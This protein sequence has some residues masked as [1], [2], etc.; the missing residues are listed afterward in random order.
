[1][2][3]PNLISP[4]LDGFYIGTA[5]SQHDGVCC[6]PAKKENSDQRYIVKVL[7][8]PPS[9]SQLEALLLTGAFR[10]TGAAVEY[11]RELADK[12]DR[13]A[14]CL[15][16]LARLEGFLAFDG[17]Q[18]VP[19]EQGS[20]GFEVWLLC[21]YRNSLEQH[22]RRNTLSHLEALNLGIDMCNALSAARRA[23][24]I[25]VDLKPSNIFISES[26]EYRIGDLGLMELDGLDLAALP[27]KYRSAYTAPELQDEMLSPNTTLDTYAL[28]LILYRIYN[29][30]Q[31]PQVVHPTEDVLPP[32]ANADYELSEILLKACDPNPAKRWESPVEM[33]QALVAYMQ[34]N[35]V[36][37]L[38]IIPP[39]AELDPEQEPEDLSAANQDETLP[40]MNEE[41]DVSEEELSPEMAKMMEQADELIQHEL[42]AP[43]VVPEGTTLEAL[44]AELLKSAESG[45][46]ENPELKAMLDHLDKQEAAQAVPD[47]SLDIQ[48]A[49]IL[50]HTKEA[51]DPADKKTPSAKKEKAVKQKKEKSYT[52][53]DHKR[54]KARFKS[55][56]ITL[57]V[58]LVLALLGYAGFRYYTDCYVQMIH[59]LSVDGSEDTMTVLLDAD[60]D[61]ELLTVICTDTFGNTSRQP[62]E[63]GRAEF[64]NLLPD[65]LYQIR[66]EIEGFHRLAG[67]TT[68]EY[69]T[70]AETRIVSYTAVTGPEDGSVILNF[71][72]DGPDSE[73]WTAVCTAEGAETVSSRFTGHMA[74]VNGLQVGT[75]YQIRLVPATGLYIP[76]E[77]SL[78]FT[79]AS[80]IIA[81]NLSITTDGQGN[82][83]VTWQAPEGA[84][85]DS[86]DVHCYSVDGYEQKLTTGE[87]TATFQGISSG[88]A[89][90]VEVTAAGM[91][92][93][94]RAGITANPIY[95]ENIQV[96]DNNLKNLTV[97]WDFTGNAPEGGWLL[98]YTIDGS[99]H[100]QVV[101]CQ[102][103]SGVI[104]V[105]VPAATYDLTIQAADGSTVF[106]NTHSYRT[107]NT[108]VYQNAP[109]AFY[110]RAQAGHFFVNMLKTPEIAN[111]NHTHVNQ[112]MYTTTFAPGDGVSVLMYYMK[113]FYIRHEDIT[114][115]YV[116]RDENGNVLSEYIAIEN[117]DWRDDLWNGPNYHY[118]AL[119]VPLVPTEPGKYI[120]GIYFDGQAMTAAE[121]TI[122]E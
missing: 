43:P 79:A 103:N 45:K 85:V 49:A 27:A 74:V 118:C 90:T 72:V 13:E 37:D 87:L 116:I 36:Q 4:L 94:A 1:M 12:A 61:S 105:R 93:P 102:S 111:W 10:N 98:M 78:E 8:I 18:I 122:G 112:G 26:R 97:T 24:W 35:A 60:I 82:L 21:E 42:P 46:N 65:M 73:E 55:F 88:S 47:E 57:C 51:K 99:K 117:L 108:D 2:S 41:S 17:W 22:F 64:T 121:F 83:T 71:T 62:V 86:W 95:V 104:E 107:P 5:L 6:Y 9:Q 44:E 33:G 48:A 40:E 11:F 14:Q 56:L 106:Q 23:G 115:M 54:R 34:R 58:V 110:R 3:E 84:E 101:Q 31:L 39:R 52:D 80:I 120:L 15:K 109:Q 59:S 75:T 53:L 76:G 114:V 119:D 28:G 77:D 20:K 32:P 69:A 67:S 68:H 50:E 113:D 100:A 66:V 91:T 89:Y 92:Q 81:E 25:Y 7:S 63:N 38:P 16:N 96:T 30:G 29:N 70:P 19:M